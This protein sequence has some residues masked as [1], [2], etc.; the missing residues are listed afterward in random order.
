MPVAIAY[1][2]TDDQKTFKTP[3]ELLQL[4]GRRK[5]SLR[6]KHN[7]SFVSSTLQITSGPRE[8]QMLTGQEG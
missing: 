5:P 8:E 6:R 4:S 1:L 7:Y 2:W 3:I